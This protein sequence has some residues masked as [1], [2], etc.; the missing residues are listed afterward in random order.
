MTKMFIKIFVSNFVCCFK[1]VEYFFISLYFFSVVFGFRNVFRKFS[2]S[3]TLIA[4]VLNFI[5]TDDIYGP[6]PC[7]GCPVSFSVLLLIFL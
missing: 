6:V 5:R 4:C 2:N 7:I 3:L 1:V